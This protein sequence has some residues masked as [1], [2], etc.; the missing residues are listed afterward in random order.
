M[1]HIQDAILNYQ[2]ILHH[3]WPM[4]P[5]GII[6]FKIL[7]K[8]KWIQNAE[9][10]KEK[11]AAST[12]FFNSVMRENAGRAVRGE[13]VM[14]FEEQEML[15]KDVLIAHGIPN[16]VPIGRIPKVDV[17]KQKQRTPETRSTAGGSKHPSAAKFQV[18]K[19]GG[20]GCC[21]GYNEGV[22]KNPTKTKAGCKDT[23]GREFAH[24]CNKFLTS[25]QTH[26]LGDHSRSKHV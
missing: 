12:A 13:V 1:T 20:L 6:I 18:A 14:S 10:L 23:L 25:S 21:Y 19:V 5:T 2:A 3:L 16:S 4:D 26:C 8:Y 9:G 15:L 17:Q 7:N 24:N 22:C 11:V